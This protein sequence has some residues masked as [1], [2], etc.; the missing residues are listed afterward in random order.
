[1]M[2]SIE[3]GVESKGGSYNG[4]QVIPAEIAVNRN[5]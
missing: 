3:K 2:V 4:A 1:M 5:L